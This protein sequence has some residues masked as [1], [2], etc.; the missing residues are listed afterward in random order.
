MLLY[1]LLLFH[2]ISWFESQK[3]LIKPYHI[4]RTWFLNIIEDESNPK[5]LEYNSH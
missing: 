4:F 2:V 1:F 5:H 3:C